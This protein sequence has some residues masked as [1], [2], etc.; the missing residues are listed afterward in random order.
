VHGT[1][2]RHASASAEHARRTTSRPRDNH[3]GRVSSAPTSSILIVSTVLI[4]PE[5]SSVMLLIGGLTS[6]LSGIPAPALFQQRP[7]R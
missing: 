7:G 4:W 1:I 6:T 2:S 3:D 5:A